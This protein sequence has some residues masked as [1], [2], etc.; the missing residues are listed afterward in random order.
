MPVQI[1]FPNHDGLLGVP[2]IDGFIEDEDFIEAGF[3]VS[4]GEVDPGWASASRITY[5]ADAAVGAGR[6]LAVLQALKHGGQDYIYLAFIVRRDTHFNDEDRIILVFH[7]DYAAGSA[8]KTGDERR[9][10]IWPNSDGL[11]AGVAD[12]MGSA[13][14]ENRDPRNITYFRWDMG[15]SQWSDIAPLAGSIH[16]ISNAEVKVRSWDL[17]VN[18]KNWSVEIKLPTTI[19]LGGAEWIDFTNNFGFYCNA[20]RVCSGAECSHDPVPLIGDAFQFTWPRADYASNDRLITGI[21]SLADIPPA[22]LSEA[23]LGNVPG[24]TGVTGVKF[25]NGPNSIGVLSGGAITNQIHAINPNDFVA[26]VINTGAS[27]A[28]E[29]TAEFRIANWGMGPGDFNKW[30]LIPPDAGFSNPSASA[31]IPAPVGGGAPVPVDLTT[32]WTLDPVTERPLY[33]GALDDH[34]CIWVLLDSV[35]AVDFAQASTRRNMNFVGLSEYEKDAEISGVGYPEPP[36]GVSDHDFLLIA[37]QM[38]RGRL[39]PGGDLMTPSERNMYRLSHGRT[40]QGGKTYQDPKGNRGWWMELLRHWLS[41]LKIIYEWVWVMDGYRKTAL[42]MQVKNDT[43]QIYQPTASFGYL[44]EHEGLVQ[45]WQ[46]SVS[47]A[48]GDEERFSATRQNAY[49]LRVPHDGS[50]RIITRLQAEEFERPWWFWLLFLLLLPILIILWLIL[51]MRS[52]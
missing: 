1:C 2:T 32:R 14:R 45:D 18:N 29:V 24:C 48:P 19:A 12:G 5:V 15:T 44:A 50:A 40:F 39:V 33:G 38:R 28:D 9:I 13:L 47:P 8:A 25:E 17:G 30:N 27:D 11:G 43:Y 6:P 4:E 10:D 49:Q 51:R 46:Q 16:A 31:T 26:R 20:I 7:P 23:F 36:E 37:S 22:W 42:T 35:Q 52:S 41:R 3:G 34:Q 21:V